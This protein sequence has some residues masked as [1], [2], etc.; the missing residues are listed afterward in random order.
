MVNFDKYCIF[1]YLC[2]CF[3]VCFIF[4]GFI[5]FQ[6]YKSKE[7]VC[8][9]KEQVI[10]D[11]MYMYE[12]VCEKFVYRYNFRIYLVLLKQILFV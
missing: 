12:G 4:D 6:L 2:R 9:D 8:Q 5:E 7:L 1:V 11:M 10:Y 3:V